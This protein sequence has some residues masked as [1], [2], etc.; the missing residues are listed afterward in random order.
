MGLQ[1]LEYY[2]N[3]SGNNAAN[4]ITVV[5]KGAANSVIPASNNHKK[6]TGK[7]LLGS[8]ALLSDC[9][10]A[11]NKPEN[12]RLDSAAW[13]ANLNF[14]Q[15]V[16]VCGSVHMKRQNRE[17]NLETETLLAPSIVGNK[18]IPTSWEPMGVGETPSLFPGKQSP[19]SSS[20]SLWLP[21]SLSLSLYMSLCLSLT[22]SHVTCWRCW[23]GGRSGGDSLTSLPWQWRAR[24]V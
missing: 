20:V 6:Q 8:D 16:C 21:L 15:N 22:H 17:D 5:L 14:D 24:R 7:I 19:F 18:L 11:W 10:S 4:C 3:L 12:K 1:F 23:G 13:S 2:C 9:G